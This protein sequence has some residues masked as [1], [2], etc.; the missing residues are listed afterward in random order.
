MKCLI[1]AA[2]YGTRLYPLTENQAKP[3]IEVAGR[4]MIEHILDKVDKIDKVDEV[5]IVH[6]EKFKA[7][8]RNWLDGY[9]SSMNITLFNDGSTDDS[10]KL[11]AIGDMLFV[12]EKSGLD[13]D[14][15]VIAGDNLFGWDLSPF[16]E[17][18]DCKGTCAAL[19]RV[20]EK[21]LIKKY[22][23]VEL[24]EKSR[25]IS[26]EEKPENPATD[27]AAICLY[28]IARTKLHK[29]SQYID[30][31]RNPDAPGYFIKY[32]V[33]TDEVYGVPLEG[34]WLDIGDFKS[35]DEAEKLF[36]R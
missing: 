22:S 7:N 32:L 23:V 14:L 4:P 3:L 2:G 20:R 34:D 6:N 35:L 18:F 9:A 15:L 26:F 31:G 13:D 12:L 10:D 27:L 36:G 25:I 16:I 8:F 28:A 30:E 33:E 21:E 29:F 11:G 1:L 19:Y 17:F 24:D 5:F